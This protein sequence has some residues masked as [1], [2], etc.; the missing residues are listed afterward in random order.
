MPKTKDGGF[1]AVHKGH[2]PGVYTSWPDCEAQVKGFRGA[3]YKKFATSRDAE[4]FVESGQALPD[5]ASTT[6][7]KSS[8]TRNAPV[9]HHP[10]ETGQHHASRAPREAEPSSSTSS[11]IRG[12]GQ[13][14]RME[15]DPQIASLFVQPTPVGARP[16][17]EVASAKGPR[18]FHSLSTND[19][20][21]GGAQSDADIVYTDG[22]CRGNGKAGA[23]A[24]IG[25]WWG[26]DD[27]RNLSER[28]P[29]AQTNNRAELIAIVRTLETTP[30]EPNAGTTHPLNELP[31]DERRRK[32][33]IRTDSQYSISCIE[34]WSQNWERSGWVS[35]GGKEVK[36][37]ALI[38][39]LLSL[40]QLRAYYGHRV[41]FE[42]V[43][44]HSGIE[45]TM[46]PMR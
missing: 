22:A 37:K 27:P 2:T 12:H 42:Y 39:Y 15:P 38:Q 6:S 11:G 32:L 26:S 46:R 43:R 28:C 19:K 35:K 1:Y 40:L 41:M 8:A 45:A 25:V 18:S 16:V 23:V 17:Q 20:V 30:L 13:R 10:Y 4:S 44:G 36:N 33:V 29:G 14:P 7:G 21:K 5:T 24:G 31:H 3:M 9:R 34:Q